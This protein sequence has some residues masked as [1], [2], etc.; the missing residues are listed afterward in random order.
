[1]V[2][3]RLNLKSPFVPGINGFVEMIYFRSLAVT[4]HAL[5]RIG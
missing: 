3:S 2:I 4:R 1:M 5:G